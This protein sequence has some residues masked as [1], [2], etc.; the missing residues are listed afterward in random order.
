MKSF[1]ITNAGISAMCYCEGFACFAC[2]TKS[3]DIMLFSF[4][5]GITI[6]TLVGH[7]DSIISL[8]YHDQRIFSVSRD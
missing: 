1:Y 2:A 3:N 4:D 5:K 7:D 8:L 6:N